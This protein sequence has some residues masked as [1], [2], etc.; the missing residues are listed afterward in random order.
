MQ[1]EATPMKTNHLP[2]NNFKMLR[3]FLEALYVI[4]I[5]SLLLN[6]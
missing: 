5:S 2:P 6:Q 1:V 3:Q 4:G